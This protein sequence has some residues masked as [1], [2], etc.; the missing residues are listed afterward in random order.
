MQALDCESRSNIRLP[1]KAIQNKNGC[2]FTSTCQ[3]I[4]LGYHVGDTVSRPYAWSSQN[5]VL[6]EIYKTVIKY[7]NLLYQNFKCKD[8]NL[9]AESLRL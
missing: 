2:H 6:Q 4:R 1:R 7:T 9:V 5:L 3:S 8:A